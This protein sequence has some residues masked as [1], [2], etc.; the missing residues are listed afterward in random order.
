MD[1][2]KFTLAV[3]DI[4]AYLLPGTL[5]LVLLSVG[6]ATF[7]SSSTLKLSQ[8]KQLAVPFLIGAYFLGHLANSVGTVLTER[9]KWLRVP[10]GGA[11]SDRL[12]TQIRNRVV[13]TFGIDVSTL[14]NQKLETLAVYKF[15]DS[16]VVAKD[17]AAERESLLLREAFALS[18]LGVFVLWSVVGVAA[19]ING[20]LAFRIDAAKTMLDRGPTIAIT[21]AALILAFV[22]WR[23]YRRFALQRRSSIYTLF[24]ALTAKVP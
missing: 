4:F 13:L 8:F 6:E 1:L 14:D 17:K 9:V 11:L 21:V 15:A 20:G 22:F 23:R 5:L 16:F 7:L 10:R 2:S 12:F 24:M 3:F 18:T 19:A